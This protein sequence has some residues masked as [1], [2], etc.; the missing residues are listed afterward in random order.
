MRYKNR[1]RRISKRNKKQR[2]HPKRF[3]HFAIQRRKDQ[4]NDADGSDRNPCP[5]RCVVHVRLQPEGDEHDRTKINAIGHG[6]IENGDGIGRILNSANSMSGLGRVPPDDEKSE[7]DQ[8]SI[9][10][11]RI[12][13]ERNQS[14]C[15]PLSK[16]DLQA[17]LKVQERSGRPYPVILW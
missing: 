8:R 6:D 17:R 12:Q 14:Y 5:N 7:R 10:N 11:L 13:G 4:G 3:T 1:I 15:S 2:N 16:Q 9:P